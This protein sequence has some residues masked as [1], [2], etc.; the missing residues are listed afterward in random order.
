MISSPDDEKNTSD[1]ARVQSTHR[2]SACEEGNR[3]FSSNLGV[4]ITSHSAHDSADDCDDDS[5]DSDVV[6][7][8]HS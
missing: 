2:L 6:I 4:V 7:I 3:V 8:A 1:I 5:S